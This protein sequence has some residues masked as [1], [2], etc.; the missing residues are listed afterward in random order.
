MEPGRR[1]WLRAAGLVAAALLLA[2]AGEAG[3]VRGAAAAGSASAQPAFTT[4]QAPGGAATAGK[5]V[6][7]LTFDDGPG[8]FTPAVLSVLEQSRVPATF[9]EIGDE[10]VRYPQIARQV[11]AAGYP[12]EDHTWS[13]PDL[14]AIPVSGVASQ[15]DMTQSEIRAV[16]GTTPACVRP[17]YDAWNGAVLD[18]VAS[19][20]LTTM[21]Y[22]VDPKDWT[23]PG[24]QAIVNGVVG[25][26]FP[27][28]VVDM[29]D[30]GGD[31]SETVAALPQIIS[32]LRALGYSFVPICGQAPGF[33][34]QVTA[35]Y[36]F[37][38][39]PAPGPAVTSSL[40]LVGA[41]G[42][43]GAYW[44]VASDGGIFSFGGAAFHGSMGGTPLNA[45]IVGMAATPSGAG[46]WEV[47]SDGGIFS[48][49]D[50][51]FHG[52]MGG[53]PLN[54]PI[55][56]MAATPSGAGYWEV[57]SDGGI[58][59]FGDAAFH[60]SMG[61]TP[62][63]APIVGMAATPSGAG[64]WEVASDGG[65]FSFGDAA[66]HGSMGGTPLNAPIVG[67]AATPG[68]AGYWEL[69]ADGGL[70]NFDAAFYGSR[71][72]QGTDRFFALVP[73]PDGGGYLL[74]GQH[75]AGP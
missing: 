68:G 70:F 41:A 34:P 3:G 9:F 23:L 32:R 2:G 5:R 43:A 42:G 17:P 49:G 13:H 63:N 22:S 46:Y 4:S 47:A 14:T 40:P 31:R 25:A 28:A 38:D 33:G 8:P 15:I 53:T 72:G 1:R 52:S 19:L 7:A 16:T 35:T 56:G 12:V 30:A 58:F 57:A 29:H 67:M 27:G 20:G 11:V 54:A 24:V 36:A 62:L 75:P 55:V 10:V 65:I 73:T 51:A 37:G 39:A 59:S 26:A 69:A 71:G 6:I 50:A 45:P 44:E 74:T 66:F 60:G 48:F 64:Y 61:G 18:Q 21:S